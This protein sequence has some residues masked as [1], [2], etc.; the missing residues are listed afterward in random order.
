[1]RQNVHGNV[2]WYLDGLDPDTRDAAREAARRAGV[3]LD[4]WLHATISDRAA[5]AFAENPPT[6]RRRPA[7]AQPQAHG[8]DDLDAVASRI[9]RVT[10]GRNA[11]AQAQQRGHDAPVRGVDAIVAA[12]GAEAERKARES[13]TRTADALDSVARWIERAED[14]MS[15]STRL[16]SEGTR[17]AL[18]RQDRTANVLGEALALMTKRLDDIERKVVEGR[19]PSV[20]AAMEA[21]GK[22]EGQLARFSDPD[23]RRPAATSQAAQVESALRGFEQ[24]IASISGKLGQSN[25]EAGR[26]EPAAKAASGDRLDALRSDIARLASQLETIRPN[27]AETAGAASQLRRG[28]GDLADRVATLAT[29]DDIAALEIDLKELSR[30]AVAAAKAGRE[31]DLARINGLIER[32]Q[33]EIDRI[34]AE[35]ASGAYGEAGREFRALSARVEEFA[36][37]D[38]R[39]ATALGRELETVR[40]SLSK[41]ADPQRLADLQENIRDLSHRVGHL[42]RNQVTPVDFAGLRSAVEEIRGA[43][44]KAPDDAEGPDFSAL[45]KQYGSIVDRLDS[46]AASAGKR[47]TE[48]LSRELAAMAAG[49]VDLRDGAKAADIEAL[50]ER[51]AAL[52]DSIEAIADSQPDLGRELGELRRSVEATLSDIRSAAPAEINALKASI[53]RLAQERP[54]HDLGRELT[55]LRRGL[56]TGL[57]DVK[58]ALPTEFGALKARIDQLAH[59]RSKVDLAPVTEQIARLAE[60]LEDIRAEARPDFGQ[61]FDEMRAGLE[62]A[63]ASVPASRSPELGALIERIDRLDENVR[64]IDVRGGVRT[65]EDMLAQLATRLDAADRP[66]AGAETVDALESQIDAIARKLESERDASVEAVASAARSAV[67]DSFGT[68]S[69]SSFAETAANADI[70]ELSRSLS[71]IKELQSQAQARGV[72]AVG[73]VQSTLDKLVERLASLESRMQPATQQARAANAQK[74]RA[75]PRPAEPSA[76]PARPDAKSEIRSEFKTDA[77]RP[78][79]PVANASFRPE[80]TPAGLLD[81]AKSRAGIGSAATGVSL[82]DEADRPVAT[83]GSLGGDVPLE[84]GVGR[85]RSQAGADAGDPALIKASF[86]AAAR[87]AAQNAAAE[88]AAAGRRGPSVDARAGALRAGMPDKSAVAAAVAGRRRPLLMAAAAVVLA[89]GAF[90]IGSS[91]I[92]SVENADLAG[93]PR[94]FADPVLADV[95]PDPAPAAALPERAP[96]LA[97]VEGEDD[98]REFP[99]VTASIDAG[100]AVPQEPA[101]IGMDDLL[102]LGEAPVID[103]E[104]VHTGV[105][106]ALPPRRHPA[107]RAASGEDIGSQPFAATAMPARATTLY[108]SMVSAEE[109]PA[110]AGPEDLRKAVLAGDVSAVYEFA[111]RAADGRDM[112]RDPALAAKL[113]ERAA[114]HGLVPAQFRIG[115]HY[116]KGIGVTRD[117]SLASLWYQRAA[118]GGNAR[119]MHNLAVLLAE[120]VNGA[121][122]YSAAL[123]WFRRAA[124]HGVRDSQY[125]LAVLLARGLGAQQDLEESFV[126]FAVAAQQGDTDA[127]GKR[128]EVASRL[129][130]RSLAIARARVEGWRPEVPRP[131]ANE[132]AFPASSID[133]PQA[134]QAGSPAFAG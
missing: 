53:D 61:A 69:R 124:E 105:A 71:E 39:L 30:E 3:S 55:Q 96:A 17:M 18:E 41:L 113:F 131:E 11:Q 125:N 104:T 89:I 25:A 47:E 2:P 23:E 12:V 13:A 54:G 82:H 56:V 133:S 51:V 62:T 58:S 102:P 42:A 78:S 16:L 101:V 48:L 15:E 1:M 117:F 87:R 123:G 106:P 79:A 6:V 100:F 22:I 35:A 114:A 7:P 81:L 77:R 38:Q 112:N 67:A 108:P 64:A 65:L 19:N 33:A 36:S 44:K 40:D 21:M 103:G 50:S 75:Q 73:G 107:A 88:A 31:T 99:T 24:R 9:A 29:R 91:V 45:E 98:R 14:R 32:V 116:E 46:L 26:E 109:L 27:R 122:D 34:A 130:E 49:L 68:L 5:R 110:E 60:K 126:W 119:A 127:A 20:G 70:D 120:G 132:V 111:S 93:E 97:A 129:D 94:E 37:S 4:D 128:D 84:P 74:R 115:N 8:Y 85:P 121:P 72:E 28:V 10:R 76:A 95:A 43:I 59:E 80:I 52:G 134:R 83:V 66:N 86:I 92:S 90:Q 63:L 118:E 57:A